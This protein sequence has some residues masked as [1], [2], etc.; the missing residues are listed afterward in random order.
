MIPYHFN[1]RIMSRSAQGDSTPSHNY[2]GEQKFTITSSGPDTSHDIPLC[3]T[4]PAVSAITQASGHTKNL[5]GRSGVDTPHSNNVMLIMSGHIGPLLGSEI[6][7]ARPGDAETCQ[8]LIAQF[9]TW[10][11]WTAAKRTWWTGTP[12]LKLKLVLWCHAKVGKSTFG[13]PICRHP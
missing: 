2:F 12:V 7:A 5:S 8:S 13:P 6:A 3:L 9:E 4:M 1:H 11:L 10:G